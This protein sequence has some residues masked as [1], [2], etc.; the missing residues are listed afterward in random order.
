[1]AV[2]SLRMGI[3][4]EVLLCAKKMQ[5]QCKA[6]PEEFAKS[7]A[8]HYNAN[9]RRRPGQ[10]EMRLAFDTWHSSEDPTNFRYWSVL[11]ESSIDSDEGHCKSLSCSS[12]RP[13]KNPWLLFLL[14]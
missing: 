4:I 13:C 8:R 12:M 2:S 14:C 6:S 1:M 10:I 7:L 11:E 9:V 3:E 5:D